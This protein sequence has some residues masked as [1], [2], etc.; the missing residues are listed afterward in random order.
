M[1]TECSDW[2]LANAATLATLTHISSAVAGTGVRFCLDSGDQTGH[3]ADPAPFR[4]VAGG[5]GEGARPFRHSVLVQNCALCMSDTKRLCLVS[6][7]AGGGKPVFCRTL[8][9]AISDH[10]LSLISLA[11]NLSTIT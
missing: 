4:S 3:G 8:V 10:F 11:L 2:F 6:D 5:W 9:I 7:F 1:I